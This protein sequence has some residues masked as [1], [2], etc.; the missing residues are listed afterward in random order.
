MERKRLSERIIE[1]LEELVADVRS[2]KVKIPGPVLVLDE[3]SY[4]GEQVANF[5]HQFGLTQGDLAHLLN[6]SRKTV[7]SWEQGIRRPS[8]TAMRM[9]QLLEDE[10]LSRIVFDVIN[11]RP[12][13]E[14]MKR[15]SNGKPPKK[16]E[17][18]RRPK[19]GTNG[20]GHRAASRSK[21][22]VGR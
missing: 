17:P 20:N 8:G 16:T 11:A 6:V 1:G 13:P 14:W 18:A 2:G 10:A 21:K 12:L 7:E 22:S 4:I 15:G 9:M 3:P 5:R 19:N